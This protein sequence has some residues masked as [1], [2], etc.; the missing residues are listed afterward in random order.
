VRLSAIPAIDLVHRYSVAAPDGVRLLTLGKMPGH[1]KPG[2]S[3]VF[4]H[5][6]RT[7]DETGWSMVADLPAGVRQPSFGWADFADVVRVVVEPTAKSQLTARRLA[8]IVANP[9]AR[10]VVVVSKWRPGDDADA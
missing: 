1:M 3:A 10:V 8:G 7:F 9:D 4:R 2:S 6:V 5:V